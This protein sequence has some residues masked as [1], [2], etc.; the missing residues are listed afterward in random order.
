M[1][2]RMA[3]F[4][5]GVM[6]S[7]PALAQ[8]APNPEGA[9]LR[10]LSQGGQPITVED[11]SQAKD[12]ED[13][14]AVQARIEQLLTD[15]DKARRTR[16]DGGGAAGRPEG[17]VPQVPAA[18]GPAPAPVVQIPAQGYAVTKISGR[19]GDY[20]AVLVDS[21]GRWISV[22]KGTELDKDTKVV[23]VTFDGVRVANGN[24]SQG[25][26]LPFAA[27]A[28]SGGG[29]GQGAPLVMPA[30]MPPQIMPGR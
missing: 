28:A 4:L 29:G 13:R 11:L 7:G 8:G 1:V 20:E 14:L 21:S 9:V 12:L 27:V 24:G 18:L 2:N 30:V 6:A 25:R 5:V 19:N 26:V 15:I 10:K 22:R 17:E 16:S 3:I 23:A